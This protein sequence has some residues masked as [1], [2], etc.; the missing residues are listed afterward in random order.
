MRAKNRKVTTPKQRRESVDTAYHACS[1][2]PPVTLKA[3]AEYAGITERSMRDRL[4]E[5]SDAYTVKDG[6]VKK[7]EES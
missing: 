3:M 2:E 7:N 1:I 6:Y 5:A 4:K